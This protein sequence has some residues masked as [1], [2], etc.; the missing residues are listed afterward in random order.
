[1]IQA[2]TFFIL[3]R[4]HDWTLFGVAFALIGLCY[5]GG[6]GTMP[7]FAADYFGPKFMG[8]IY[9]AVLLVGNLAAIPSPILIAHIHQDVGSYIPALHLVLTVMLCALI[10]PLLARRPT[11]TLTPAPGII[12]TD[13]IL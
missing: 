4:I 10:V 2:F 9:G 11:K 6:L 3:P 8:G 5:G 7:S 12:P 1:L 13:E